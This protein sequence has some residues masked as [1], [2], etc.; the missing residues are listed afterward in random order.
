MD[1]DIL[2]IVTIP[3]YHES[4][5]MITELVSIYEIS[6]SGIDPSNYD[7]DQFNNNSTNPFVRAND[8][9]ILANWF[10]YIVGAID[11]ETIETTTEHEIEKLIFPNNRF[12]Y[13]KTTES[14]DIIYS[15]QACTILV[16]NR[17]Q[18]L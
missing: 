18:N 9:V 15:D 12:F 6:V 7:L 11:S 17:I 13:R 16:A 8:A 2:L 10:D 14:T 1:E 5:D 3:Q 4:E